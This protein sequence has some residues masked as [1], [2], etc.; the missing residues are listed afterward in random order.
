MILSRPSLR[1]LGE[2]ARYISGESPAAAEQMGL[3]LCPALLARQARPAK[4]AAGI[5]PKALLPV[6]ARSSVR[7]T[8]RVSSRTFLPSAASSRRRP[9]ARAGRRAH[10]AG[11]A[12]AAHTESPRV[13]RAA[14]PGSAMRRWV[15]YSTRH[16]EIG[17]SRI[18]ISTENTNRLKLLRSTP[19]PPRSRRLT[20]AREFLCGLCDLGVKNFGRLA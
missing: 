9:D 8:L 19:R 14:Y 12:A 6:R 10:S 20:S 16:N 1:D 18:G 15:R 2:I 5:A 3:E 7:A 11:R 4:L 17:N 13:C